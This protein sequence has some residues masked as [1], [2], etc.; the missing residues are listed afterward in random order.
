MLG[1][2]SSIVH[3]SPGVYVLIDTYTSDF[4][5]GAGDDSSTW[6]A[7][8]NEGDAPTFTTNTDS[9]GGENDWLKVEFNSNQTVA[10][11]IQSTLDSRTW[12]TG[13]K[14]MYSYKIY[15]AG[16]WETTD[17]V[18]LNQVW[19]QSVTRTHD[20]LTSMT[21]GTISHVVQTI[22]NSY[23]WARPRIPQDTVVGVSGV[24]Y[25][26]GATSGYASRLAIYNAA[27]GEEP[28][29]GATMHIKD[30]EIKTYRRFG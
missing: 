12:E 3:G 1:L 30:L 8:S 14:L 4:T 22:G 15:I 23:Q 6:S 21:S 11:G 25:I 7:Y 13:D 28:Q 9:I 16:D 5:G 24:A 20:Q 26:Q 19:A 18:G 10:S 27:A 17:E 29:D 2:G